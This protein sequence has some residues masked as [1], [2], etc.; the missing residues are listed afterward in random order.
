MRTSREGTRGIVT[1][2]GAAVP[3]T[4]ALMDARDRRERRRA[5][6]M[7]FWPAF[8]LGMAITADD[9]LLSMNSND[10]EFVPPQALEPRQVRESRPLEE[11]GL[12]RNSIDDGDIQLGWR[13]TGPGDF[14]GQTLLVD[15]TNNEVVKEFGF[16]S[17]HLFEHVSRCGGIGAT[18]SGMLWPRDGHV[19]IAYRRWRGG[20]TPPNALYSLGLDLLTD[21]PSDYRPDVWDFDLLKGD[22]VHLGRLPMDMRLASISPN[23]KLAICDWEYVCYRMYRR[24]RMVGDCWT[25]YLV[26]LDS[27]TL[28]GKL[29]VPGPAVFLSNEAALVFSLYGVA[30]VELATGEYQIIE[31]FAAGRQGG[32]NPLRSCWYRKEGREYLGVLTEWYDPDFRYLLRIELTDPPKI[33]RVDLDFSAFEALTASKVEPWN[34]GGINYGRELLVLAIDRTQDPDHP[35]YLLTHARTGAILHRQTVRNMK[36]IGQDHLQVI[37]DEDLPG[38]PVMRRVPL[39]QPTQGVQAAPMGAFDE[40]FM[41]GEEALAVGDMYS[42]SDS[43]EECIDGIMTSAVDRLTTGSLTATKLVPIP[44][45]RRVNHYTALDEI[46]PAGSGR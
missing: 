42:W 36:F 31:P 4:G 3:D 13:R 46:L 5:W 20:C 40:G 6:R 45:R 15:L 34:L 25:G 39:P 41:G 38:P 11:I 16:P 24:E 44:L 17:Y 22:V 30:R 8:L 19:A 12:A 2:N 26:S 23:G 18:S 27:G 35:E 29:P 10:G 1:H 28:L 33:E 9:L 43:P 32:M 7:V 21:W 37:D 14:D